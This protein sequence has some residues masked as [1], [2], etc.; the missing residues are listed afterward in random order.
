MEFKLIFK[1]INNTLNAEEKAIFDAWYTESPEH[2]AYFERVL[3][4]HD[5]DLDLVDI[6]KGWDQVSSKIDTG[7][8]KA[9]YWRY[10]AAI[11]A[12]FVLG[13]LALVLSPD[14]QSPVVDN[15]VP[16]K[17][18]SIQPGMDKAVLT[19]EDGSTVALEEGGSYS[20][21]NL[22]SNGTSLTY[23]KS[24]GSVETVLHNVLTI[25]RG[26]QFSLSLADGTQV[27][28]NSETRLRYP[29]AFPKNATRQVELLYGEAYF[30]VSPSSAHEGA[31]FVVKQKEQHIEV[32]GT[33][34]NIK[35]YVGED[36]VAT[37]LVEGSIVLK[38]GPIAKE[39]SP[40]QQ[41]VVNIRTDEVRIAEVDVFNEVSWKNGF[42]SFEDKPLG[43]IMTVLSRWYDVEV[44]YGDE[45]VK[46]KT[47][48]GVFK[49]SS[50]IDEILMMI[51]NT[52]EVTYSINQKTITMK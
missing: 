47:F 17:K 38:K 34:F 51:G 42:F 32:L 13:T 36:F 45:E 18:D 14:S 37:T 6:Q 24:K 44:V 10:A 15:E 5:K 8:K 22:S 2:R 11:A 20:K 25:P 28:L 49:K 30:E 19:L 3:K 50:G 4:N 27:W 12:L 41:S 52:N 9:N 23:A 29:I 35:A 1:K 46:G 43:E 48:N 40:G 33:A 26:G 16:V 31:R 21:D 39:L 7:R